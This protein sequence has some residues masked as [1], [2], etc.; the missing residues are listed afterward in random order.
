METLEYALQRAGQMI[1]AASDIRSAVCQSPVTTMAR[2]SVVCLTTTDRDLEIK[3][4]RSATKCLAE[5]PVVP[6]DMSLHMTTTYI[7]HALIERF[8]DSYGTPSGPEATSEY[9][10]HD[11]RPW[12]LWR[13]GA[14]MCS[15]SP[16]LHTAYLSVSTA[17]SGLSLNDNQL[18]CAGARSYPS[19]LARLQEALNHVEKSKSD[20]VLLT[21]GLCMIYEGRL[22][23]DAKS[24]YSVHIN[25]LLRLLEYRGVARHKTGLSHFLFI[26]TRL[27][28]TWGAIL[29]RR[30][31][32]LASQPW[33]TIPWS[34]GS[35]EKDFAQHLFDE[36]LEIPRLLSYY[37]QF[38]NNGNSHEREYLHKRIAKLATDI[39]SRLCQWKQDW[40]DRIPQRRPW[41]VMFTHPSHGLPIFRYTDPNNPTNL[42]EPPSLFYP[43]CAVFSAVCNH[44]AAILVVLEVIRLLDGQPRDQNQLAVAHE[45]CRSCNY[46]MLHLPYSMMGRVV[47]AVTA[48]YDILPPG[49]I[50]RRYLEELY[51]CCV[52]GTW[53]VFENFVE[54]FS[55]ATSAGFGIEA[56]SEVLRVRRDRWLPWER[57][58]PHHRR[59]TAGHA[60]RCMQAMQGASAVN[61]VV[62]NMRRLLLGRVDRNVLEDMTRL[63]GEVDTFKTNIKELLGSRSWP[64]RA[65]AGPY[66]SKRNKR[67]PL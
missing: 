25:G 33:K 64:A 23:R 17:Y 4:D 16:L 35:T 41:E 52:G 6:I 37:D 47:M 11:G 53:R 46:F 3:D 36:M 61:G 49:G 24:G 19:V 13:L 27:Y 20:A 12:C 39:D 58:Q 55:C 7:W 30:P 2:R 60:K 59:H 26:D 67:N 66:R 45:I 62:R 18:I 32:F 9:W 48:A 1:Q 15:F 56:I 43:N 31:S 40:I 28:C 51:P 44:Y 21:V 50:E 5:R 10:I 42:I 57:N 8:V 54:E 22:S 63:F 34:S 38:K 65:A 29:A 14:E